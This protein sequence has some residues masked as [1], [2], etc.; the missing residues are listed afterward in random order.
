MRVF[1]AIELPL[2]VK[3]QLD[4]Q[5]STLKKEYAVFNWVAKENFHI[6]LIF[7][8]EIRRGPELDKI[9]QK[10]EEAS[11]DVNVFRLYSFGADLFLNSKIVLHINFKREK[12]LEELVSKIKN[13][14]QIEDQKKFVPHLTIARY[15]VPSKQQYFHLKKKL[16][17]LSIDIDLSVTKIHLFQSILEEQKPIYK[18]LASFPL[19]K[20]IRS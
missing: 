15:R 1:L 16:Q 13:N 10:V 6:T 19:L 9:K 17:K 5:I 12:T 18:K 14:L 7:F 3:R 2:R 8:G 11:Y 20:Q 4:A